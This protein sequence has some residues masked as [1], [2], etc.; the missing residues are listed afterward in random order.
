VPLAVTVP[1]IVKAASRA[2][3]SV[4]ISRIPRVNA[5]QCATRGFKV[6]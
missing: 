3:L 5:S 4:D 1:L 6:A 2:G